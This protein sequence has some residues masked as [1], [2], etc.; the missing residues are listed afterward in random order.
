M[1]KP[2]YLIITVSVAILSLYSC[3]NEIST[4]PEQEA[5]SLQRLS[6]V[7]FPIPDDAKDFQFP[8]GDMTEIK[9]HWPVGGWLIPDGNKIAKTIAA[10][11]D[12][13]QA[14]PKPAEVA[15]AMNMTLGEY[16]FICSRIKTARMSSPWD[17][18]AQQEQ[19]LTFMEDR[20]AP[21]SLPW[22]HFKA[23]QYGLLR[24]PD[25]DVEADKPHF[26]SLWVRSDFM[27]GRSP[28][29]IFWYDVGLEAIAISFYSLPDTKG[30]WKRYGFY[31]RSLSDTKNAHFTLHFP[32][33]DDAFIDMTG[34]QLRSATE[35]EFSAAYKEWRKT[36]PEHQIVE[37]P[38]DGK[39]LA[40]S[41]AKLEGKA[42]IPGKPFVI[43]GVGSSW[44][45]GLDDIEPVR[46]AI[47]ARFPQAP[48][49]IY[50][51]IVGSGSPYDYIRGWIHTTVLAD[52]PDLILSYTNGSVE[53]LELML[54]DI[55]EN[56]T[57]DIIIPSLHFFENE[58]DRLTPEVINMPVFDQI[59]AVCEKYN[60]QF[61]DN[62]RAIAHW[63]TTNNK[64]VK[65]LLSD[66]VHQ[67][68]QGRLLTCENIGQHFVKH[69]SPAYDP[70]KMESKISLA[71]NFLNRDTSRLAFSGDWSVIGNSVVAKKAGSAIRITFT[72]NR[73]DL[74]GNR[75][76]DGGNV[77]IL[78]DG[79]PA[80]E[81]S[82]YTIS[83]I[84][85]AITNISH[86]GFYPRWSGGGGDTGPHGIWLGNNIIPQRWTIRMMDDKGNYE[87][88]GNI[89]KKDGT[90][91]NTAMFN[92][93]SG[94][95]IIDPTVWRHPQANVNGDNWTFHVTRSA[96]DTVNFAASKTD[97]AT[98]TN[99]LSESFS[100]KLVW[101]M[102]NAQHTLEIKTLDE[103]EVS[104]ESFYI[105][106]P[107]I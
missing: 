24:S 90:G 23:G 36:M 79:K 6:D 72:G 25:F 97:L 46:Q 37:S 9:N 17:D 38:D 55:R 19:Q 82:A 77:E 102:K 14:I 40:S 106:T 29:F 61:V 42:G 35:S 27:D 104:I 28:E 80:G 71:A 1:K 47:I 3:R 107:Q 7:H 69:P 21:D 41:I 87:L 66:V 32:G 33:K 92:S 44:T 63:L 8:N 96:V 4:A 45:N 67:N 76:T 56:T 53:G 58:N 60:A 39:Y 86:M 16:D 105:F 98:S 54:Q 20:S 73:I 34:F 48:E 30:E 13:N 15:F 84:R 5:F 26:M 88:E 22:L 59:K 91:N 85:P 57:A 70:D 64:H 75:K 89:T 74:I 12:Y 62:R 49:I 100:T 18:P 103:N 99:N 94:Q 93:L 43:W 51:K 68:N 81:V 10:L 101:N 52:Q 2:Y 50:R 78:I 83:Y 95:I 31:F 65:D 11:V